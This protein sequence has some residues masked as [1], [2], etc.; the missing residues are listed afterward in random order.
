[1]KICYTIECLRQ[2]QA[3]KW[4][5]HVR[6]KNKVAPFL[7]KSKMKS[8][9]VWNWLFKNDKNAKIIL[10]E[11][12]AADTSPSGISYRTQKVVNRSRCCEKY[13]VGAVIKAKEEALIINRSFLGVPIYPNFLYVSIFHNQFSVSSFHWS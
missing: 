13:K 5:R 8:C 4:C 9:V 12:H 10:A 7:E 3:I 1:M 2:N 11:W 6:S